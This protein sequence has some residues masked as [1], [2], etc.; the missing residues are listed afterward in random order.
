MHAISKVKMNVNGKCRGLQ[1]EI[2]VSSADFTIYTT[3]IAT[4]SYTFHLLWEEFSTFSEAN[5]IHNSPFS[6]PP[7]TDYSWVSRDGMV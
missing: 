3:G 6:V 4:L 7:G 5:A 1:A 2:P